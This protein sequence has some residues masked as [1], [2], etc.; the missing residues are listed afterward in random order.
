MLTKEEKEKITKKEKNT[1][2]TVTQIKLLTEKINKMIDHLKKSPKDIHSK[3]GFLTMLSDRKKLLKYLE[4]EDE[5]T[6][7]EVLKKIKLKK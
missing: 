6:Y 3:R 2:G 5:K 4:R 7:Q 1:G